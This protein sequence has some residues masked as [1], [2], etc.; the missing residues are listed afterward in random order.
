[1]V[2][3]RLLPY[4]LLLF[5]VLYPLTLAAASRQI[6]TADQQDSSSQQVPTQSSA[7]ISGHVYRADT[8]EPLSDAVVF[9]EPQEAVLHRASRRREQNRMEVSYFLRLPRETTTLMLVLWVL[10]KDLWSRW[11]TE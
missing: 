7:R 9:L 10:R 6:Q 11:A 4:T 8:G 5:W 2:S 3:T 1:M